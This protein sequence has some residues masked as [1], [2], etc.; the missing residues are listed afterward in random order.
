VTDCKRDSRFPLNQPIWVEKCH[1]RR[2]P[3]S[4]TNQVAAF[5]WSVLVFGSG[6]ALVPAPCRF[7]FKHDYLAGCCPE[8]SLDEDEFRAIER[9][10]GTVDLGSPTFEPPGTRIEAGPFEPQGHGSGAY[11]PELFGTPRPRDGRLSYSACFR[12]FFSNL[13]PG[14]I[15]GVADD[16]PGR[17]LD[18]FGSPA[19][20]SATRPCGP[21]CLPPAHRCSAKFPPTA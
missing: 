16:D 2:A 9:I 15:T 19:P 10:A 13:G 21:P 6:R 1:R 8:G 18:V 7:G 12:R 20:R 4:I 11:E 14:L 17:H 5:P 3:R